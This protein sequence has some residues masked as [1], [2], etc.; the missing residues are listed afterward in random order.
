MVLAALVEVYWVF[1]PDRRTLVC[2]HWRHVDGH[3]KL[4]STE[5]VKKTETVEMKAA[6]L[7]LVARRL[8]LEELG[9][10]AFE[11]SSDLSHPS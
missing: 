10:D 9:H 1:P 6:M 5:Q 4:A 7:V 3:V 11:W 2:W 8:G